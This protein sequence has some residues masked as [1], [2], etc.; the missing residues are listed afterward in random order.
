MYKYTFQMLL[1][2]LLIYLYKYKVINIYSLFKSINIRM[3]NW[4]II[5]T[6]ILLYENYYYFNFY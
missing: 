5:F 6:F 1:S 3:R 2:Y 4:K